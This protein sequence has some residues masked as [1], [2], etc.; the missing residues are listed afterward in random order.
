MVSDGTIHMCV[1]MTE[2]LVPNNQENNIHN[3]ISIVLKM[4]YLSIVF[5]PYQSIKATKAV[6]CLKNVRRLFS[7]TRPASHTF[8]LS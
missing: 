3:T 2:L 1:E 6:L 7:V 4:Q 8:G 5:A